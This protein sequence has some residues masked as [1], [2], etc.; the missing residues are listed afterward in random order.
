MQSQSPWQT[1]RTHLSYIPEPSI[2][3]PFVSGTL[4]TPY[5][6]PL[7]LMALYSSFFLDPK[8]D[9]SQNGRHHCAPGVSI[10]FA[11]R[12]FFQ[13][14]CSGSLRTSTRE[15]HNPLRIGEFFPTATNDIGLVSALGLPTIKSLS[16]FLIRAQSRPSSRGLRMKRSIYKLL[17]TQPLLETAKE[18]FDPGCINF[19]SSR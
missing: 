19:K 11:S 12:N 4:S 5:K 9:S 8:G 7:S 10:L 13:L 17:P 1:K 14:S 3:I 16:R 2:S 18:I 6:S 15:S